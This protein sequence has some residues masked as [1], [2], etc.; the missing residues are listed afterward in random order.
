MRGAVR[1]GMMRVGDGIGSARLALAPPS[2][3]DATA[4]CTETITPEVRPLGS[5]QLGTA[6]P[7]VLYVYGNSQ[8]LDRRGTHYL[9]GEYKIGVGHLF[10]NLT[11][12]YNSRRTRGAGLYR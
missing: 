1:Q 10:F 3:T 7:R 8:N 9:K 11:V 2:R 6:Y 4:G 12:E 5:Q